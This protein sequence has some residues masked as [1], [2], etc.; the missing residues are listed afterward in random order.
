MSPLLFVLCMEYFTRIRRYVGKQP[1]YKYYPR[2]SSLEMNH[3]CFADDMV[4]SA[5]G[6]TFQ[7]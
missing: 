2:C 1:N 4:I 6:I 7:C 5:K 3:L